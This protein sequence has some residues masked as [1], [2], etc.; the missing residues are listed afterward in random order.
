MGLSIKKIIH[1]IN[2][3]LFWAALYKVQRM[4]YNWK[5]SLQESLSPNVGAE[6]SRGGAIASKKVRIINAAGVSVEV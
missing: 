5:K 1:K 4:Y 3:C 6:S 2:T